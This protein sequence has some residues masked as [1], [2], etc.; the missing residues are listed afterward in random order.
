VGEYSFQKIALEWVA[1]KSPGWSPL[2]REKTLTILEKDVFPY[3][4]DRPIDEISA[5]ELLMVLKRIDARSSATARKAYSSCK[6][7]FLH[8]IPSGKI[9]V[10]PPK[11]SIII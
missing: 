8:T 9:V 5:A 2:H 4:S 6:Q 11:G 1:L 7:V 3:I 10:S